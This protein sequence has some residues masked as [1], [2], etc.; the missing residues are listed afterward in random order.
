MSEQRPL[1]TVSLT[2]CLP[3]IFLVLEKG[4][5]A[6]SSSEDADEQIVLSLEFLSFHTNSCT[7]A[8]TGYEFYMLTES[9]FRSAPTAPRAH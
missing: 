9:R 7:N 2:Y 3:L 6:R 1:D 8:G 4:G 5:I